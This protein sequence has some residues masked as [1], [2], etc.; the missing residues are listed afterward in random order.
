MEYSDLN[1]ELSE[2]YW[3]KKTVDLTKIIVIF[4]PNLLWLFEHKNNSSNIY[5]YIRFVYHYYSRI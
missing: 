3:E 5:T 1:L 4:G 2:P